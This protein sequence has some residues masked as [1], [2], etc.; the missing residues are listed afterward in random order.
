MEAIRQ[1]IEVKDNSIKV[2]LPKEFTFKRVE[3]IILPSDEELSDETKAI[4]DSR[5]KDYC[6]NP[7]DV[8]DFEALLDEL[9]NK[10]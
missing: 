7:D 8:E 3:V 9:E 10:L 4:L 5:L 6:E 1:F 2:I